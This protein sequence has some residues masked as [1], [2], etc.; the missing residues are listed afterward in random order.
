MYILTILGIIYVIYLCVAFF[1]YTWNIF[2]NLAP[3]IFPD[4]QIIRENMKL[5]KNH[6]KNNIDII[7]PN[8]LGTIYRIKNKN[9]PYTIILFP[10][11]Y[12]KSIDFLNLIADLHNY[13]TIITFDQF[14]NSHKINLVDIEN[15]YLNMFKLAI[16]EFKFDYTKVSINGV[17][18][19]CNSIVN[20]LGNRNILIDKTCPICKFFDEI[21]NNLYSI[22]FMNPLIYDGY[23][24]YLSN[25]LNN[26]KLRGN[27]FIKN[28]YSLDRMT[29]VL[30]KNTK[31]M[32]ISDNLSRTALLRSKLTTSTNPLVVEIKL[33]NN[34]N[35]VYLDEEYMYI[36]GDFY[37]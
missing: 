4:I 5:F 28:N 2:E 18:L 25:L 15:Y 17:G 35:N 6:F 24:D 12:L 30:N 20:L 31:I 9:S 10:D 13:G 23:F 21:T 32:I 36:M 34:G 14:Y 29:Y 19:G 7:I 37:K 26:N 8:K 3:S 1:Y 11:P 22:V 16:S 33:Q 27:Y